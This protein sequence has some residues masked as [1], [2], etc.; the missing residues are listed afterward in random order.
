MIMIIIINNSNANCV[1][2]RQED[3]WG[4]T[5]IAPFLIS[6]LEEGTTTTATTTTITTTTTDVMYSQQLKD[7]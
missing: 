7:E 5:G 3:V 6:T 1:R 4:S 2:P